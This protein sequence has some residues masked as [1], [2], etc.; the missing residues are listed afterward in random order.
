MKIITLSEIDDY[1][2]YEKVS[3]ACACGVITTLTINTLRV[4]YRKRGSY[5]CRF[6]R[7]KEIGEKL[8]KDAVIRGVVSDYSEFKCVDCGQIFKI[9]IKNARANIKRN[10]GVYKCNGCSVKVA[11][12][13]GKF[14]DIYTDE[15]KSKLKKASEEFW[16]ENRYKNKYE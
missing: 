15:F 5:K 16:L 2:S 1:K 13:Q 9:I 4:F 7:A 12:C 3:I 11:H 8:H 14:S 6:C 10:G